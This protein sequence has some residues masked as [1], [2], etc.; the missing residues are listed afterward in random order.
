[1]H[2]LRIKN[3]II[4]N[5]GSKIR[6]GPLYYSIVGTVKSDMKYPFFIT[7][8]DSQKILH[9]KKYAIFKFGT[10]LVTNEVRNSF[11][12]FHFTLTLSVKSDSIVS[13]CCEL[14]DST[15][16][17]YKV[18]IHSTTVV[19]KLFT[20]RTTSTNIMPPRTTIMTDN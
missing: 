1:M 14:I 20:A 12:Y 5:K 8:L 2:R 10:E 19:L 3:N 4:N 9:R 16:E 11:V 7:P 6:T 17:N 18:S 15:C 13:T